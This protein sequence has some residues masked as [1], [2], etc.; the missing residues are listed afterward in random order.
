MRKKKSEQKVE[1]EAS[2][3][4][5]LTSVHPWAK[6]P[7]KNDHTV[8]RVAAS[9]IRF[10][11]GR[12]LMAR[13]ED[14][15]LIAGHATHRAALKLPELYERATPGERKNW[16]PEAVRTVTR[17]E[18]PVRFKDV[19]AR[20]AHALAIAENSASRVLR[21]GRATPPGGARGSRGG[22]S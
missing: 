5:P 17:S 16:H 18:V 10:G 2:L 19:S 21:L 9:L 15:E 4:S 3:W 22:L 1:G 11:W 20:E 12:P 14:G 7:K 8:D 13:L 6:N